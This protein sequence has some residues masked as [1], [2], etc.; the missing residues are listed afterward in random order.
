[1]PV[2]THHIPSPTAHR[3]PPLF[4]SRLLTGGFFG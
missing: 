1:L 3:F 2:F 4:L